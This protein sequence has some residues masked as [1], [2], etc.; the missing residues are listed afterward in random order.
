MPQLPTVQLIGAQKA[1]TSALADWLF[2]QG[3]FARPIVFQGEPWFYSKEA[4]F[5]DIDTRFA[6]GL[7]FYKK[8]YEQCAMAMDATPDTLAFPDR[9]HAVYE[10]AGEVDCVKIIVILREPIARELS[11][12]NHLAHDW[13]T[14]SESDK[15]GWNRQ[16]LKPDGS[17]MGFQDFVES[18]SVPALVKEHGPGRSTRY[19][20]YAMHLRK[21]FD[22][23]DRKQ[24]LVLSYD[25]LKNHPKR[26]QDRV[27]KFLGQA[28]PGDLKYCNSN[29]N[30]LKIKQP[31]RQAKEALAKILDPLNEDLYS[32]LE[33]NRG[34]SMEQYPFPR[35]VSQ[36]P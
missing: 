28:I 6:K 14:L 11:L 4:H 16:V 36:P 24:I 25:E 35:F 33:Q 8:R 29:D 30:P 13:R 26:L 32:L 34:P 20:M 19:S 23:F 22:R 18:V 21:W 12:Y 9:V 10:A 3:G 27:R 17:L 1:G 7:E 15:S 31:P 2:D 5:F